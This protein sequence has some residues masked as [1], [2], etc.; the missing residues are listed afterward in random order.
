MKKKKSF[1]IKLIIFLFVI[2]MI[3]LIYIKVKDFV[4]NKDST[5]LQ[6]REV[7]ENV[8]KSEY[9]D[10]TKYIVYGTHFNIE[11]TVEIPKISEISISKASVIIK[12]LKGEE[13]ILESD[14]S[15]KNGVLA[16]STI[17][18]IN[19]GLDLE[20]LEI[21]QYYFLLKVV[22]SNNEE[23]YYSLENKTDYKNIT[24][25]TVTK[26]ESN[27]K[28]DI[29]FNTYENIP[30]M[31]IQVSKASE[32]PKDVYD[33]VIDPG[34]GGKD[35]G[36]I[37]GKNSEADIVLNAAMILKN[38]LEASGYK[39]L[40]TRD[41]KLPEDTNTAYNMYDDDGR[42]TIINEAHSKILISLHLNSNS[43]K[44]S[45]GGVE[46]YAPSEC[47][48][49]FAK[50]LAKNIV[51]TANT[52][53]SSLTAYKQDEGVYVRNFTNADILS[54][55]SSAKKSGYKPYEITTSTPYLYVIREIGGIIT[56]A[57]V[58][59]R[60]KIYSANKY[61][62]SNVGTEGYLIE[63]G[64]M[65]I[66]KDLKNI[67]KHSDLYMQAIVNSIKEKFN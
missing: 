43:A 52:S 26:N 21:E 51:K 55:E 11:G 61:C 54:F 67:T 2:L 50:L 48:L 58:D 46:V 7:F 17:E 19:T 65:S 47:N 56:N 20:K 66:D 40:L 15:Y 42:I 64:Y 35:S 29:G 3:C 25:Y 28:I 49:D 57:F 10:V 6:M 32:L 31:Q 9:V 44:L 16:F 1:K 23:K 41:E 18:E 8:S 27:N 5:S 36:A 45:S 60:N 13:Q 22:F 24:Y 38:K 39:V 30:F 34:H 33:I 62:N 53:Y 59:G 63:L 37:N 14:Y 4:S 12:N